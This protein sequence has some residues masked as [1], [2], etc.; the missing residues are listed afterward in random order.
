M[1]PPSP[2]VTAY[3]VGAVKLTEGPY[4]AYG[5]PGT[6]VTKPPAPPPPA[7]V[8]KYPLASPPAPP[9]PTTTYSAEGIADDV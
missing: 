1:V 8:E 5:F 7:C 3:G 4:G 9:P 2:T 6:L